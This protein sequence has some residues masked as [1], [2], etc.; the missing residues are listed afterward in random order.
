MNHPLILID[1]VLLKD[2]SHLKLLHRYRIF[3]QHAVESETF[4]FRYFV[5]E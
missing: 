1:G 5:S 3:G 4:R 2:R